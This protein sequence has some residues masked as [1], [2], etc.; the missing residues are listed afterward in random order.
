MLRHQLPVHSP[1][2]LRAA[3]AG[4]AAVVRG[5][6]SRA[7]EDRISTLLA[8]RYGAIDVALTDSGTSALR[9]AIEASF[10]ERKGPV[11]LPGYA[12]YDLATAAEGAR[13]R[14]L[15][16]DV[17][18]E[19]LGPADDALGLLADVRPVAVVVAHL[20]GYPAPLDGVREAVPGALLIEDAAQAAGGRLGSRLLGSLGS[21]S[22]LS[23]G[24]GKGMTGGGGGALLAHDER[25]A[26]ALRHARERLADDPP[27]RGA[28][29]LA[30]L[31]AQWALGRPSLYGAPA[32]LPFLHLGETRYVPPHAPGRAPAACLA[33]LERTVESSDQEVEVRRMHARRLSLAAVRAGLRPVR[34]V[35]DAEPG[36]LRLGVLAPERARHARLVR[37]GRRL[38]IHPMYPSTL[39]ALPSLKP[40]LADPAPR[41]PGSRALV[42][43]LLALPTHGLLAERDLEALEAVLAG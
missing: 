40:L 30:A 13:A 31:V 34:A 14:V 25:G 42:D 10:R 33:V 17:D 9:L 41:L 35:R 15:L 29:R 36:Y 32:S 43:S 11:A 2:P 26:A 8:D 4:A 1:V 19:T 18:P 5:D 7:L 3:L 28:S 22:V 24:R 12:C 23:F 16:Y 27:G 20:F 6:P 37:S 38:G 21:V 39:D